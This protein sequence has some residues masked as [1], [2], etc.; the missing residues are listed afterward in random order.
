[1]LSS[2]C[3]SKKGTEKVAGAFG[4]IM[5]LWFWPLL[6]QVSY[7]SLNPII[8][9]GDKSA[10]RYHISHPKWNCRFFVLS[11]VILCATGGEALYADMGHLGRNP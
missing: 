7:Q 10:L 9:E 4:P 11:E 6:F 3:I 8:L 2:L 5:L 1:L